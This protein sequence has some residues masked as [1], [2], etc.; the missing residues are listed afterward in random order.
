MADRPNLE[1]EESLVAATKKIQP[2]WNV[3]VTP[4]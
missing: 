2:N 3:P 1:V 4:G